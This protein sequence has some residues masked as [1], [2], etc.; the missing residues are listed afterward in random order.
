M[1]DGWFNLLGVSLKLSSYGNYEIGVYIKATDSLS[2]DTF[3]LPHS[4][5]QQSVCQQ[6]TRINS[7]K[8]LLDMGCLE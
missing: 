1:K 3:Q 7:L 5:P 4:R 6:D 2:K 8:T